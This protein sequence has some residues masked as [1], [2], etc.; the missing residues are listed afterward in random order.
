M[1]PHNK[2]ITTTEKIPREK[3]DLKMWVAPGPFLDGEPIP[4]SSTLI[5]CSG[6]ITSEKSF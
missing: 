2:L 1:C 6:D 4:S 5:F 3:G